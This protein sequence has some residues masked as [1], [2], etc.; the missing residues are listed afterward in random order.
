MIPV[1]DELDM[2]N[3]VAEKAKLDNFYLLL[4]KI[5]TLNGGSGDVVDDFSVSLEIGEAYKNAISEIMPSLSGTA[6][7]PGMDW[8]LLTFNKAN[9][10]T[11]E[12]MIAEATNT[13]F[14]QAGANQLVVSSGNSTSNYAIKMSIANDLA[15][16]SLLLSRLEFNY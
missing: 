16:T 1:L 8:G 6:L 9:S 12:S 4:L 10:Q 3:I 7:L 5:P 2:E 15:Y 13:I 14:S 11:D